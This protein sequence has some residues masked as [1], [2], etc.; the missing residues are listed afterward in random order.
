MRA[1]KK[2]EDLFFISKTKSNLDGEDQ[3][4]N[5]SKIKKPKLSLEEKMKNLACYR[6]LK[7]DPHSAPVPSV[8]R[9]SKS[10]IENSNRQEKLKEKLA[11]V[12]K[13]KLDKKKS[14]KLDN[15]KENK[16]NF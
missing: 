5:L 10:P 16:N 4:E 14:T 13:K 2:D 6:N 15:K 11:K 7:P 8:N 9:C 3:K 12:Y 1:E